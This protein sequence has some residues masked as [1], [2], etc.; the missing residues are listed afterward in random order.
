M[1]GVDG[2]SDDDGVFL[3]GAT[4][5]SAAPLSRPSCNH[6]RSQTA[7]VDPAAK[8]AF[9]SSISMCF[10]IQKKKGLRSHNVRGHDCVSH[11]LS[12]S[13][14]SRADA[15]AGTPPY[16]ARGG[17]P[18]GSKWWGGGWQLTVQDA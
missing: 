2:H 14:T 5:S 9:S 1:P 13:P 15:P 12:L 6:E 16:A 8:D 3:Q 11:Q 18:F 7:G 17:R 4:R 10:C